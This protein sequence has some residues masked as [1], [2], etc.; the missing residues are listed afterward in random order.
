VSS[1]VLY[2]RSDGVAWI[3]LNRPE[4]KNAIDREMH[5]ALCDIWADYQNDDSVEVAILTGA[6]DSFS[7]GMDLK[8]HVTEFVGGT[9]KQIAEWAEVGLGGLP[10]GF[11]WLDKPV[12]AAVNGWALGGGFELALAADIRIASDQARF[13][14]FEARWGLHPGEGGI[15]R[16]VNHCG[17]AAAMELVL[18]ADPIDAERALHLGLVSKVVPESELLST[19]EALAVTI[20]GNDQAAVRSAKR[21][22]LEMV[23][24]QLDDQ[25]YR[26]VI[27]AYTLVTTNP[28]VPALLDQLHQRTDQG[29]AGGNA[30]ANQ[31]HS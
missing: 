12:I 4:N 10:R 25:L 26:E 24:R 15:A 3:T 14:S 5:D 18:T 20:R 30:R 7:S 13:G 22:I 8:T 28:T 17:V 29:Q 16:L 1:P 21:T 9:P 11:H 31:E 6:G 23:G 19:A 2:T 27:A